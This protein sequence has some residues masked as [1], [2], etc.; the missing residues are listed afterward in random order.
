MNII[1][2]G[3]GRIGADLA[4]RLFQQGHQVTVVDNVPQAFERLNPEFRGRTVEGEALSKEVLERAGAEKADGL[5]AVANSDTLNAV[6]AHIARTIYKIP[7][8][9][10]R[11]YDPNLRGVL[12][13]FGFQIVSSSAWGAQR[14]EELL[15]SAS[16][17]A[18]FSPG[19]GEVEVYEM[20]V[21]ENWAGRKLGE[22]LGGMG[23]ACLPV[24]L[25]RAGRSSLPTPETALETGDMLAVSTTAQGIACLRNALAGKEA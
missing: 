21:P 16:T 13:A 11:N 3:C 1:I 2:V 10:V 18:V 20:I 17:R 19:N 12:E 24:A 22:L 4:L 25:T 14:T 6:V 7:N 8:V 15:G 23:D 5:A 9:V